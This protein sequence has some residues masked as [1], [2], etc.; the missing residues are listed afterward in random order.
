M[1]VLVAVVLGFVGVGAGVGALGG[2]CVKPGRFECQSSAQCQNGNTPGVCEPTGAC[3]FADPGCSGGRRYG[4]FAPD[5]LANQCIGD[6]A[7]DGGMRDA[8]G[9]DA[10]AGSVTVTPGTTSLLAT[11]SLQFSAAVAA[12]DMR[13][14]WTVMEAGGGS[15]SATGLYT[16]PLTEGVYHVRATSMV[17][18]ARH[19]DAEITVR[20]VLTPVV[21]ASAGTLANATGAGHQTH[22][23]YARGVGAWWLLYNSGAA[24]RRLKTAHSLDFVSWNAGDELSLA[25]DHSGDGRDLA[26]AYKQLGGKDVLHISQ[27]YTGPLGRYHVRAVISGA[28]ISFGVPNDVNSGAGATPDGTAVLIMDDG[29][30]IDSTGYLPTPATP[31]LSPCGYGDIVIYTADLKDTGTT[32]FDVMTYARRVLWCVPNTVNARALV[33]LGPRVHHLYEPGDAE[34][35]PNLIM[36]VREPSGSWLP[37]ESGGSAVMPPPVFPVDAP[38]P[39]EDWSVVTLGSTMHVVRRAGASH[40]TFEHR[41]YTAAGGWMTSAAPPSEA[42]KT[43]TGIFLARYA[44]GLVAVA[45]RDDGAVRYSTWNGST[46]AAWATLVGTTANRLAIAGGSADDDSVRPAVIWTQQNGASYDIMGVQL[47]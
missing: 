11:A 34:P 37:D 27:G 33:Q 24:L 29:T 23:V 31:P 41:F 43:D 1:R 22:L 42:G 8:Q 15:I 6:A 39:I 25:K 9:P 7:G 13:V 44:G 35:A 17:D 32:N 10:S 16:A 38:T 4:G 36:N 3:S 14:T 40:D 30:V 20:R 47:P 12:T 19:G 5:G 2:G 26:V 21:L 45:L 46:W 28:S 18:S